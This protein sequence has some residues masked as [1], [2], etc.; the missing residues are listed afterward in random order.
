MA[1]I[2]LR[3]VT[4]R[5]VDG[6]S[7]TAAVDDTLANLDT[8]MDI[9]TLGTSGLIPVLSRFTVVGSSQKYYTVTAANG[10]EI[11]TLTIDATGG[12]F[13]I[14]WDG[15]GP[16]SALDYDATASEVQTAL[17]ALANIDS[18]DVSVTGSDGG[19][20]TIEFTGQYLNTAV[21]EITTDAGSLTGGAGTATPLTVHQGGVTHN[22]TFTPALA[23]AAGIPADDAAITFSGRQL[24]VKLGDG[25][26]TYTENKE[27]DYILDRGVLD[28]VRQGDDQPMDISLDFV[29]EFI[30]AVA[31]SGT[32]TIEDALKRIGE[33]ADW[34]SSSSDTCEP[35]A[36]DLEIEHVPP[37]SGEQR[38]IITLPD[39][40]YES[41]EHDPSEAAI[42]VSGRCN[43]TQA[44][45]VRA[46]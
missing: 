7:N 11:Q 39:F 38:E 41:L 13:T 46:A 9:D 15:E 37:C 22:I 35:Y 3:N 26:L 40:R 44:S 42:S 34:T 31:D 25:T 28:T 17:E 6:H 5:I 10:N 20:Y 36:V 27:F 21:A 12:T 16:T 32:P 33:A 30:T 2:E 45:V 18:G 23:T 1:R 24:E 8:E 29:W 19:P 4:I 14:S 43:A